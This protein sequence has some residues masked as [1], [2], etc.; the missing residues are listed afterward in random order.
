MIDCKSKQIIAVP[1]NIDLNSLGWA[2]LYRDYV[3]AY[4]G[5]S[6]KIISNRGTQF[7]SKFTTD[8]YKLLDIE[9]NPFTIYHL[10]TDG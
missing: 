3:Y 9:P 10:Q 2:K 7:I 5:L 1:T 4:Y 8:L 6:D